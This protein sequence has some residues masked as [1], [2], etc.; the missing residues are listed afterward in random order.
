MGGSLRAERSYTWAWLFLLCPCPPREVTDL[1]A[2]GTVPYSLPSLTPD[3]QACVQGFKDAPL[4]PWSCPELSLVLYPEQPMLHFARSTLLGPLD[5]HG[6][7]GNEVIAP[8][9]SHHQSPVLHHP[10]GSLLLHILYPPQSRL[11]PVTFS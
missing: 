3:P 1:R 7:E 8:S 11:I 4:H 6:K 5:P 10:D 9:Q 2:D